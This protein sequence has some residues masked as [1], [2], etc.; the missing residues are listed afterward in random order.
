MSSRAQVGGIDTPFIRRA[1]RP[2]E[3][4]NGLQED[5]TFIWYVSLRP[6]TDQVRPNPM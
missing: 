4:V 6:N 3:R 5:L 2:F 1:G